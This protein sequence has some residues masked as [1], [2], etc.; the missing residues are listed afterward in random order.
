M[1]Y[2]T[3]YDEFVQLFPDD[4]Y[5]VKQ[6]AE[7]ASAEPSDGMHI[8]FG[9]VIVPFLMYLLAQGNKQKIAI[10]FDFFEKMAKSEDS[11]ISEVLEFSVL[12]DIISRGKDIL[13]QF[14]PYMKK[15]TLER[16]REVEKYM[17]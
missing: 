2:E 10:A 12:E 3:L 16:C 7:D 4:R 9:M 6:M 15:K 5:I 8:M 1:T 17:M 11:M 13:E 14:K